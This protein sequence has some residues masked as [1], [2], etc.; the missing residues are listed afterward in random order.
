MILKMIIVLFFIVCGLAQEITAENFPIEIDV[1]EEDLG[2]IFQNLR[3]Y[4]F[5]FEIT[6]FGEAKKQF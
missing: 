1:Y 6:S 4:H 2:T 3:K 5:I